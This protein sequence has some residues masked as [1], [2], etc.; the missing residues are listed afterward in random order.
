MPPQIPPDQS[1]PE[2][3]RPNEAR[4]GDA[5]ALPLNRQRPV[6]EP[7]RPPVSRRSVLRGVAG[8]GGTWDIAVSQSPSAPAAVT[9]VADAVGFCRLAANRITTADLDPYVTGDQ[10]RAA[11]VLAAAVTLALD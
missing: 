10:D 7:P 6:P 8:V 4:I 9:I 11:A 5:Q 2:Q 3:A 1:Y